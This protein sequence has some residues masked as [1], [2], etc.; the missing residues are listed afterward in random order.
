MIPS[1]TRLEV[2]SRRKLKFD[3]GASTL[4]APPPPWEAQRPPGIELSSRLPAFVVGLCCRARDS[5][6]VCTV[7]NGPRLS[8]PIFIFSSRFFLDTS[9]TQLVQ[10]SR[11]REPFDFR[12]QFPILFGHLMPILVPSDWQ[13]VEKGP[14]S[15]FA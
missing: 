10:Y 13:P 3:P 9:S 7:V 6:H 1:R 5:R 14:F 4:N 8:S 11:K 2:R 12:F 15:A